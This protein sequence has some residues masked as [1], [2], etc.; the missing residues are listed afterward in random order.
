[1]RTTSC[2]IAWRVAYAWSLT[3]AFQLTTQKLDGAG[4]VILIG[5][6]AWSRKKAVCSPVRRRRGFRRPPTTLEVLGSSPPPGP[7]HCMVR[8]WGTKPSTA[9]AMSVSHE[10]RRNS[11][12]VKI[13]RPT[14]CLALEDRDDG[15]VFA[16][17][18]VPPG[19][20]SRGRIARARRAARRDGA[21]CRPGRRDTAEAYS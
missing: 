5:P 3:P 18:Q 6:G 8:L 2:S 21:S 15:R 10:P 1:M 16:L 4:S 13:S 11:P 7:R 19:R 12:S 20:A 14:C 9:S 17:A